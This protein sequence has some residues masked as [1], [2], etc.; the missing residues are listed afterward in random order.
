[1]KKGNSEKKH[2]KKDKSGQEESE[3]RT[4]WKGTQLKKDNS[5]KGKSEEGQFWK[6]NI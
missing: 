6:G 5:G 1:M 2:F 4:I 3:K